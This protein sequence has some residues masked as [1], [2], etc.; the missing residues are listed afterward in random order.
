LD[1]TTA[2]HLYRIAREAVTNAVKHFGIS[3]TVQDSTLSLGV[4]DDGGDLPTIPSFAE[5]M[6]LR[7]IRFEHHDGHRLLDAGEALVQYA[8]S[9]SR[10]F[11]QC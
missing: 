9:Q 4:I 2:T 10:C 3:I 8:H 7:I 5:S 6:G 1:N 11:M